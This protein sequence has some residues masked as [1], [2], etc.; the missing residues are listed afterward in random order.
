MVSHCGVGEIL[1][2]S[3]RIYLRELIEEGAPSPWTALWVIK[4]I[5]E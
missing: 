1:A 5:L 2:C 4:V 3:A